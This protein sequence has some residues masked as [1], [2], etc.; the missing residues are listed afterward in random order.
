V[1][2]FISSGL[3]RALSANG[4]AQAVQIGRAMQQLLIP[5]G[6]VLT[7]PFCRTRE[8]ARLA[9]DPADVEPSLENPLTAASEAEREV[10]AAGLCRLLS[11]L[12][13]PGTNTILVGHA[14]NLS[15]AA[16]ITIDDGGQPSFIPAVR[17]VL[18]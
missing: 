15:A 16:Q 2:I 10:R 5:V 17:A 14:A 13:D 7:G 8:T 9:F 3:S 4:Q 12:P 6:R 1:E 18:L 11:T